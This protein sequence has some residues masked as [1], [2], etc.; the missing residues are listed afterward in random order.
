MSQ[1]E[2]SKW[3]AQLSTAVLR[4]LMATISSVLIARGE[5]PGASLSEVGA[6]SSA[7]ASTS[8]GVG[9]YVS[10]AVHPPPPTARTSARAPRPYWGW[11]CDRPGCV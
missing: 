1:L 9:H 10:E 3:A 5:D 6:S 4:L 8:E 7:G 11:P 2:L